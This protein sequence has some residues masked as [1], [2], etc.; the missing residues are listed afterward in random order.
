[1]KNHF[2][3]VLLLILAAGLF[4]CQQGA[5]VNKEAN[6]KP[7]QHGSDDFKIAKPDSVLSWLKDGN[8]NFAF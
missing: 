3:I 5:E 6:T 2:A 4:S 7:V 8:D 1:M